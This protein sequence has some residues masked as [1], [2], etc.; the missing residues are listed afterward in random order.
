[1]VEDATRDLTAAEFGLS[2]YDGDQL[3]EMFD[4]LR[5][6]RLA[7]GDFSDGDP[8]AAGG[9]PAGTGGEPASAR[10]AVAPG[11]VSRP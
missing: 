1:V 11:A 2:R 8:E 7:A 4:L 3:K 10:H 9:E 5:G 6:L